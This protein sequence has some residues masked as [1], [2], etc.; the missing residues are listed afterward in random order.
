MSPISPFV[1]LHP[2]PPPPS[3]PPHVVVCVHWPR[4]HVLWQVFPL[5]GCSPSHMASGLWFL[6]LASS[7]ITLTFPVDLPIF[8]QI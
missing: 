6:C 8:I 4:I 5:F 3:G 2:D 7:I 1:L